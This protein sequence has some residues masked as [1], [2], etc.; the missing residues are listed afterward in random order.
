[1]GGLKCSA[2]SR[3]KKGRRR[4]MWYRASNASYRLNIC[5][6]GLNRLRNPDLI[7]VKSGIF[8]GETLPQTCVTR[9]GGEGGGQLIASVSGGTSMS[10]KVP[11]KIN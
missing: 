5:L 11:N 7:A 1:M 3:K 2:L 10:F 8:F 9:G 6:E 4:R